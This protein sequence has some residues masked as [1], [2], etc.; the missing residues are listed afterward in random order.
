MK[1]L[2]IAFTIIVTSCFFF[3]FNPTFFPIANTKMLVAAIGLIMFTVNMARKT[4]KSINNSILVLAIYAGIVSFLSLL[5]IIYH[6]TRDDSYVG[7]I[8]SFF[9]WTGAAYACLQ[10]IKQIH[11]HISVTLICNYLITVCVLQCIIALSMDFIPS[12]KN[13]VDGMIGSQGFMGISEGRLYGIGCANDVAGSR[14]AAILIMIAYL[15]YRNNSSSNYSMICYLS[16]FAILVVIGNMI[17]RTTLIGAGFAFAYWI[18]KSGWASRFSYTNNKKLWHWILGI[19]AIVTPITIYFYN[20]NP[21]FHHNI[22][23]AFEGFFSIVEKGYW[24]TNSNNILKTMVVFPDNLHTW[25][26]GDGYMLNPRSVDPYYVGKDFQGFYQNTDIG[27]LR[28]IFYFGIIG[29]IAIT[30][31]MVKV[32]LCCMKN[33]PK[34]KMLFFMLL[35]LNMILWFKVSTDIFLVFAPFLLITEEDDEFNVS[36]TNSNGKD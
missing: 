7:F 29:L 23:F 16:A 21:S 36:T 28:F 17:S 27:Y 13:M 35:L 20:T 26:F 31:Y 9:V 19:I 3:P 14:F 30:A 22:R 25:L 33:L 34:Y 18:Y 2:S 6:D 5:T 8:M 15:T 24:E 12:L 32:M 4:D 1:L 10:L 11:G